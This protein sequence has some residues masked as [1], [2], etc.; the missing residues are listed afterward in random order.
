MF[1]TFEG[2]EGSG[3]ST[4][5]KLLYQHLLAQGLK[6]SLT[7]EPG[8][9]EL[10]EKLRALLLTTPGV[11]DPLT[12][13]LMISA[14][15]R[16]H[17]EQFIKPK[18]Q[19]GEI[20]ISDRFFDSSCVYQGYVKNLD[21]QTISTINQLAIGGFQPHH[22]FLMDIEPQQALQRIKKDGREANYYDQQS[23]AFHRKIRDGFLQLAHQNKSRIHVIKAEGNIEEIAAKVVAIFNSY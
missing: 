1:I 19:A 7:R 17:V 6:V 2:G 15:R 3:K 10:A 11:A 8:G 23:L 12:E 20:V 21:I 14:A 5:A 4:Q 18:L 13:M 9:T 16:D 22:T